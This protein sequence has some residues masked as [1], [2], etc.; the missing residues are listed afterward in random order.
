MEGETDPSANSQSG[1]GEGGSYRRRRD[2]SVQLGHIDGGRIYQGRGGIS[3][4]KNERAD[5]TFKRD[6]SKMSE[7][8][9]VVV[10]QPNRNSSRS[11]WI[12]FS[13]C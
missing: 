7:F 4:P 10:K 2:S 6:T 8:F 1:C 9:R 13:L 12:F 3:H 5:A 11:Q